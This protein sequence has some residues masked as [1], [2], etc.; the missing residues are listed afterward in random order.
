MKAVNQGALNN[1]SSV[2]NLVFNKVFKTLQMF[3]KTML[4][5]SQK[6][7]FIVNYTF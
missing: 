4:S 1:E 6:L 3:F 5:Q 7:N 2:P